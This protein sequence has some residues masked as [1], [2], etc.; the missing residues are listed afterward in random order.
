MQINEVLT[1]FERSLSSLI[2]LTN[3]SFGDDREQD[4]QKVQVNN[5]QYIPMVEQGM[6]QVKADTFSESGS[7]YQT[8]IV[9]DNLEYISEERYQEMQ[10]TGENAFELTSSDGTA[11]YVQKSENVDV[12]VRCT[13]EDFRWRFAP[14][15]YSD[16]SLYGEPPEAYAKKT[17]RPS[18]NP[19]NTP[20]VCKH[21][22][23]L[24][25]ELEREE[26]FRSLLN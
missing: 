26:F 9:F 1:L 22:M 15:N 5:I 8:V 7:K 21:I 23:K 12:K 16:N 3:K 24:K 17:D 14:Y 20:G 18:V 4:S 13:C 10:E 19:N 6:L 25:N 2:S 11:F